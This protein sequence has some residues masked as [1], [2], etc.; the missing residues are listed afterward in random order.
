[1]A[2]LFGIIK[3]AAPKVQSDRPI[4]EVLE[5]QPDDIIKSI[6]TCEKIRQVANNCSILRKV[7]TGRFEVMT[8]EEKTTV[9][10]WSKIET[11]RIE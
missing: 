6:T 8:P 2:N 11:N 3:T 7:A 4:K 1:M 9:L 10:L 5:E